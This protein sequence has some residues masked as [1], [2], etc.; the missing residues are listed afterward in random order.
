[1]RVFADFLRF[2]WFRLTTPYSKALAV[3]WMA[4]IF[5]ELSMSILIKVLG[6]QGAKDTCEDHIKCATLYPPN[7]HPLPKAPCCACNLSS[8]CI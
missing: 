6:T 5:V 2:S 7:H 3:P 8:C 1:M 4:L